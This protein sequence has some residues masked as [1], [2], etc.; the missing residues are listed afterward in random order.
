MEVKVLTENTVYKRAFLGEHGLSLLIET[1]NQNY[2]FDMGQSD[3]FLRNGRKL[4]VDW[5]T[6]DGVVL[7]HGHY[8]HCGGINYWKNV[9]EVS[10]NRKREIPIYIAREALEDKYSENPS[11]G[12]M[13]FSGIPREAKRWMQESANI[14][15]TEKGCTQISDNVYLL[16]DVPYITEFEPLPV[17]F[18]KE[19]MPGADLEAD[20]MEDEQL[21][22]IREEKGLCVFAGCAHAGIINCLNYVQASFPG[23]RIHSLVAGMHLKGCSS[24]RLASTI[25]ALRETGADI[26]VPLHCTGL[27]A[28]AAICQAMPDVCILAETGKKIQL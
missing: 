5:E 1:E 10:E 14:I 24:R 13:L 7:S 3:V 6:L 27:T 20:T 8:D 12:E 16:S 21:L 22:V 23:E 9:Q 2:L 25:Q 28:I 15:Y 11:T 19:K 4:Q 18:W 26:I 17:R